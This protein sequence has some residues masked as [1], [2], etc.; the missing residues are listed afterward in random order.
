[1]KKTV[2]MRIGLLMLLFWSMGIAMAQQKVLRHEVQKGETLYRLSRQ[3][4]V[5]VDQIIRLNPELATD[6]LK[7]GK[8]VLIPVVET[9]ASSAEGG[10][11]EMHKVKKKETLWSISQQYGI[12][13]EEL[14][15]A[16]PEMKES[17]YKLKKGT[18]VCI[19]HA[20][21]AKPAPQPVA[22]GYDKLKI[23]VML[24]MKTDAGEAKRSVEFYRGLLMATEKMKGNGKDI[25][26]YAYDEPVASSDLS[27]VLERIRL[28]EVQLIVGPLYPGHFPEMAGFVSRENIKWLV[29]FSSKVGGIESNPN[30]FMLNTPD[31]YKSVFVSELFG[32]SFKNVKVVFLHSSKANELTLSAGLRNLLVE[33][34]Y[35]VGD[36]LPGYTAAQMGEALAPGKKTVFVPDA[37]TLPETRQLLD[38]LRRLR[39]L[40]PLADCALLGYPEWQAFPSEVRDGFYEADTYLFSPYFYNPYAQH[41]QA[42]EADYRKNFNTEPLDVY[43]RMA[44]LGYD[45]GMFWMNG[46]LKYGKDFNVQDVVTATC[47]S[48]IGFRRAGDFGGY[49]NDCM[50]FIHYKP[51]RTIEKLKAQ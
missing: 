23:A 36:L 5:T 11:R 38:E 42:F 26:I 21:Q 1:M 22:N 39:T 16:N 35:E 43:P 48:D 32:Q 37:S 4:G 2:V 25:Y 14:Q 41:T 6:G 24:P 3:Y 27:A 29:P 8:E 31:A 17:G 33:K 47:Q 30:L 46:L 45:A 44:L 12:T 40:R 50:Q 28:H 51:N 18:W 20:V 49:V 7:S 10:C 9:A 19:P 34:G 13:V 15:N